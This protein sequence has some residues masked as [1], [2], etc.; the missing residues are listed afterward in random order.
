MLHVTTRRN[1]Q[2][3]RAESGLPPSS[4]SA[5]AVQR[6]L[7]LRAYIQLIRADLYLRKGDFA[8]LRDRVRTFPR[9]QGAPE[10]DAIESVCRAID[11]ACIWYWKEVLC[12]Q[13]SAAT[14]CV[15]RAAG[16]PAQ[17]II[18]VQ[19]MPFR[20]HAWVEVNGC[21]VNDKPYMRDLYMTLDCC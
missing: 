19:L 7:F 5:A 2:K 21:V 13:R 17:M 15:L 14:A 11:T 4:L 6:M 9:A 16:I 3:Q 1:Q 18:G 10:P 12:L 20:A 8:K